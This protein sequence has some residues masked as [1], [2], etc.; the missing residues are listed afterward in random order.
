M[1][2]FGIKTK[3]DIS[4]IVGVDQFEP[5]LTECRG[6]NVDPGSLFIGRKLWRW[7]DGGL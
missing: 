1:K 3:N 5:L 7:G 2:D 4:Q 6:R